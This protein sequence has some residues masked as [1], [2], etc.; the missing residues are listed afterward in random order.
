MTRRE[1]HEPERE[2]SGTRGALLGGEL[3]RAAPGGAELAYIIVNEMF[4]LV[5]ILDARGINLQSNRTSLE[6]AGLSREDVIGRPFWETAW[7]PAETRAEV[8]AAVERAGSG[9]FVRYEVGIHGRP[10]E[11]RL[12]LDFSLKPVRDE[13]GAVRYIIAEGR[14]I[15]AKKQA[16][17]EVVRKN[18]ELRTLYVR[19]Q[20]LD[21]A[22][23]QFFANVS[24]ELRTPLALIL[25][26]TERL[27]RGDLGSTPSAQRD[28]EEIER[29]ARSLLTQVTDLLD[30]AKLDERQLQ[31]QSAETDLAAL[32]RLVAS[33]FE[34]LAADRGLSFIV[35]A[36]ERLSALVD[37]HKIERI[38][39]NLLANA[40]KF[41]REGTVRCSLTLAADRILLRVADSGPGVAVEHR[42]AIFERFFQVD[43][44]STR[45]VGG[46]GLGLAL[47]RDLAI[48]HGGTANVADAAEGGVEFTIELPLQAATPVGTGTS[49]PRWRLEA[50]P[51]LPAGLVVREPEPGRDFSTAPADDGRALVLLVEDNVDMSRFLAEVLAEEYRVVTAGDGQ[52]G[53]EKA[54]ALRPDLIL[55]DVMMPRLSGDELLRAVRAMPE[56]Q[57][58]PVVIL[59]AKDDDELRVKLLREGAQDF[60]TKPIASRELLARVGNLIQM[61]R[62]RRVLE[63]EL[64][65]RSGTLE[66]L[67]LEL[68]VHKRQLAAT[69][70]AL[71]KTE[72]QL[73]QT[74]K[75]EAIGCLAAGVA[76]DFNNLLTVILGSCAV[77]DSDL[78]AEPVAREAV[79]AIEQ[80]GIR[81]VGLTSQLLAFSRQQVLA[82]QV[83][84][85][86]DVILRMHAMLSRLIGADVEFTVN[87]APDLG[88]VKV[89]PS[90]LEQVILNLVVNARDAMPNGGILQIATAN[91]SVA[92]VTGAGS[93]EERAAAESVELAI[94]DNGVG[95]DET[96]RRRLF[97][98][99]F[100]TKDPGKGTGLGLSTVFGIVKQSGGD[101][102]VSSESGRGA[103]FRIRL[104]RSYEPAPGEAVRRREAASGGSETI[105]LAEDDEQVRVLVRKI[106][107][108][109]GYTVLA[110]RSGLEALDLQQRFSGPIQLLLTDV[111]MPAMSGPEL[112][113][114]IVVERPG[115][116]L[117]FMS[118]YTDDAALHQGVRVSALAFLQKPLAPRS[119][120]QKVREVLDGG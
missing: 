2:E 74:Q 55:S 45:R 69:L 90:Q 14:D 87:A 10:G 7:W 25:A 5:G 24:H 65:G 37:P 17:A 27:G 22:K 4:Q 46:V 97:E 107:E 16:E 12:F 115:I 114:R 92:E 6:A 20:D 68:G 91:V 19:L 116:K 32:V 111:V 8:K 89:D 64:Q 70:A 75:M 118:G 51:A 15:T 18:D 62:A 47:V 49:Q 83:V 73:R 100:T 38:L 23:S 99:F 105:L 120:A 117:L 80:A 39:M 50:P 40:F 1:L 11:G 113:R 56:L 48:L 31:L 86:N 53:L 28:V 109:C 94:S 119:L 98:P 93:P 41:T 66:A 77:L 61:R 72:S 76:H 3:K 96:T 58:V 21:R 29:H 102:E 9:E 44:G 26:R 63:A 35:E 33:S 13:A 59:T 101:V 103:T 42:A 43:G 79:Q 54:V 60:V 81:A 108:K 34:S 30:L 57:P 112:A 84:D 95:M 104:P 106:L 36:P 88:L 52:E 85:L 71:E 67:A 82:P 78:A 110:A